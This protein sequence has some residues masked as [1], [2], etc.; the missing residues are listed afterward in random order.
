M[1]L[2]S[3][4]VCSWTPDSQKF[5]DKKDEVNG[6][7]LHFEPRGQNGEKLDLTPLLAEVLG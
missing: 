5:T 1:P 4:S 6:P 3:W 2:T 7:I